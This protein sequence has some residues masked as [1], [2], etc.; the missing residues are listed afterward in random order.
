M[1]N[2]PALRFTNT[3][4]SNQHENAVVNKSWLNKQTKRAIPQ[5]D[6]LPLFL[7]FKFFSFQGESNIIDTIV[8]KIA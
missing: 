2:R 4:M 5:K 8:L 6:L 3:N 1:K 7:N